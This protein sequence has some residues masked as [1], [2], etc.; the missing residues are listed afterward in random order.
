[1]ASKLGTT[2]MNAVLSRIFGSTAYT[3]PATLYIA[4]FTTSPTDFAAGT[5]GT[6]VSGGSYARVAV[7]NNSTNFPAASS[8]ASSNGTA[9]SF[10]TPSGSWGTVVGFGI[11][12]AVTAGVWQ[13]GG[14]LTTSQTISSGNTVSFAIGAITITMT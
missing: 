11:Y 10:T 7:T 9:I 4:L 1:M 12:D 5:G 14:D 13:G 2:P 8:R 3:P 6:E